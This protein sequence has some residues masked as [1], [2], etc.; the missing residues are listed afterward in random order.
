[1]ILLDTD[2]CIEILRG[3]PRV[4]EHWKRSRVLAA[5]SFTTVGELHYGAERSGAL[6][7]NRRLVQMFLLSVHVIQSD[8]EIM[9]KFAELKNEL[10]LIGEM[11]PD[12][13]I[14][15]AATCLCKCDSLVSGNARHFKRFKHLK[16]E[17]W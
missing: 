17:C 14:L 10:A 5:V 11:L 8:N 15:I 6:D 9:R 2:V 1:M 3:T 4:A 16:M 13:D 12:A 7:K